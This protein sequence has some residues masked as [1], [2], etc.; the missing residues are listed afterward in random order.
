MKHLQNDTEKQ[1]RESIS[2]AVGA[3]NSVEALAGLREYWGRCPSPAAAGWVARSLPQLNLPAARKVKCAVCRSFTV[4]PILQQCSQVVRLWGIELDLHLGGFDAYAEAILNPDSTL[5][6]FAPEVMIFAVP[7]HALC[8]DLWYEFAQ[9]SSERVEERVVEISGFLENLLRTFRQNSSAVILVHN[10]ELPSESAWGLADARMECG[11]G[12]V[13]RRLNDVL[14]ATSRSRESVYVLDLAHEAS[15]VGSRDWFDDQRWHSMG[16]PYG[17]EG[18][19]AITQLWTRALVAAFGTQV[20]LMVV[21]LDNTLWRGILGEA[22]V[23][24]IEVGNPLGGA[25]FISRQLQQVLLNFKAA[26]GLLAICS[27]N[28]EQ[29]VWTAFPQLNFLKVGRD[30]FVAFRINWEDKASNI[31]SMVRQLNIGLDAV[32]FIDD[33]EHECAW[34]R[35]HLPQVEVLRFDYADAGW[36]IQYLQRH[37]RLARLSVSEEDRVRSF[38]YHEQEARETLKQSSCSLE[39]YWRSLR[40]ELSLP[41]MTDAVVERVAQLTQ[42]TNQFN[43]TTRRYSAAEVRDLLMNPNWDVL[44]FSLKDRFGDQ[45]IIGV[46][47]I[48][49]LDKTARLDTLLMSCRVI[50]RTVED[51]MLSVVASNC[52]LHGKESLELEFIPTEKN[53]PAGKYVEKFNE[54][55]FGEG[56][57]GYG[58][59][60]AVALDDLILMPDWFNFYG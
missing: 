39:D 3:E 23:A 6:E 47:M 50:G 21:D 40:M 36:R 27:K 20:K 37:P 17:S 26:G 31:E 33:S 29:E 4:E 30:D 52:Q 13:F 1:L 45:G 15:V 44:A 25:G 54:P 11:Q 22:G 18:V 41:E 8:P 56:G 59:H 48:E 32:L 42:K 12:A 34:V 60:F 24:G 49:Y 55:T 7:P 10:L 28:N 51:A 35:T 46:A 14:S 43:F 19:A 9:L 57:D 38:R 53:S 58:V 5:Y 2:R 16:L